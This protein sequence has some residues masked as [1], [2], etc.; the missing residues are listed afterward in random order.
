MVLVGRTRS[1]GPLTDAIRPLYVGRPYPLVTA[2]VGYFDDS[3]E[4]G[5]F[6]VAGYLAD[7]ETWDS[8]LTPEWWSTLHSMPRRV[9]EFKASDCRQGVEEFKLWPQEERIELTTKLV[10]VLAGPKYSS[11]CGVG[12]AFR[13]PPIPPELDQEFKEMAYTICLGAVVGSSLAMANLRKLGDSIRFVFDVQRKMEGIAQEMYIGVR[14]RIIR[15]LQ[16]KIEIAHRISFEDSEKLPPL[17]AADLLAHETYKE[18][19]NQ[20]ESPPRV[21][22]MALRRLLEGK[23]HVGWYYSPNV[24]LQ[25]WDD[26]DAGKPLTEMALPV[27]Y[28]SANVLASASS[29]F[30]SPSSERQ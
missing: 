23:P 8:V 25:W 12:A 29:W 5:I 26:A 6:A 1:L 4:G 11:L 18:L 28:D 17:Q 30:Q 22:S 2:L 20:D 19:K 9:S 27:I 3:R 7:V 15:D 21:R 10:S 24:I 16:Y 13:F 14:E